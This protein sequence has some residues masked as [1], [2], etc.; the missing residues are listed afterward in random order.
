M[1]DLKGDVTTGQGQVSYFLTKKAFR[2]GSVYPQVLL[3][4]SNRT[5]TR[6]PQIVFLFKK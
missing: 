5:D 3:I 6:V 4:F 1:K 2:D